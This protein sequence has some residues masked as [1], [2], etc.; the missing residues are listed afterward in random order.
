[1]VRYP[2]VSPTRM[3]SWEQDFFLAYPP[4]E[5]IKEFN[6][7]GG[8]QSQSSELTNGYI[9]LR[10]FYA[11][12]KRDQRQSLSDLGF[13]VP[14]SLVET[15]GIIRPLRHSCGHGFRIISS[16]E[17]QT[18]G[19]WD[20]N[21]EY[22]QEFYPKTH[23]YRIL[24]VR[25]EPLITLLKRVPEDTPVA[26]PWNHAHGASFVTVNNWENNRLRHTNIYD[27]IHSNSGFFKYVN[28]G[29]LDVM[30]RADESSYRVCEL[31]LCPSLSI[32]SNLEKVANH[33]L[34]LPR[35]P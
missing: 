35:Q 14:G 31:N 10:R 13:P 8:T 9:H 24:I 4:I 28:L 32:Q 6:N 1:M 33:V 7:A 17:A 15:Y 30:Y 34:S 22:I 23:E 2:L 29:G 12:N 18:P 5:R 25:G 16:L 21:T 27:L 19:S 3:L 26:A 11:A 20:P